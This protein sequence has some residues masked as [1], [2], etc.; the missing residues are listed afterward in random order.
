MIRDEFILRR[1]PGI[2]L[3]IATGRAMK[4]FDG[5]L[6][7]NDTG[8]FIFELLKRGLSLE[9]AAEELTERFDVGFE[10]AGQDISEVYRSLKE[11]GVA[12]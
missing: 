7:L 1:I 11:A 6:I 8:A 5:A 4:D 3:V 10:E 9:A 2:N 12:D